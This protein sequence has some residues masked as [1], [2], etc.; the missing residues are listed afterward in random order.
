[1]AIL[2]FWIA[3]CSGPPKGSTETAPQARPTGGSSEEPPWTE[4]TVPTGGPAGVA[5]GQGGTGK[6]SGGAPSAPGGRPAPLEVEEGIPESLKDF[7]GY[8]EAKN[9]RKTISYSGSSVLRG[10]ELFAQHC[11]V[12]HGKDGSG[13]PPAGYNRNQRTRDLREPLNYRY[14]ASDQAVYRS[15]LYGIPRSPMGSYEK[16]FTEDQ[17]WDLVNFLQSLSE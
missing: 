7:P 2:L 15:I 3:G 16:S 12:C 6:Q 10:E 11:A 14:G 4:T 1:M 13:P 17:V 9:L 5:H 8:R